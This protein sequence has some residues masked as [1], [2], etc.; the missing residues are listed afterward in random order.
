M[1]TLHHFYRIILA[2]FLFSTLSCNAFGQ[3]A[4]IHSVWIEHG[5]TQNGSNG[6]TIHADVTTHGIQGH[7]LRGIAFFYNSEKKKLM[8]GSSIVAR[9]KTTDGQ[10]C[11]YDEDSYVDYDDCHYSDFDIFM[12]YSALPLLPGKHSHYILVNFFD[13]TINRFLIDKW[14]DYISFTGTGNT[15]NNSNYNQIP[16][17]QNEPLPCIACGGTRKCSVCNGK[18]GYSSYSVNMLWHQCGACGGTG[19]CQTCR[20]R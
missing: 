16:V 7:T 14:E 9:Y 4:T 13:M 6:M 17:Y 19:I 5:T 18:G 11:A 20:F 12:P 1:K 10:V 15:Y 8:Q 2:V 3:S